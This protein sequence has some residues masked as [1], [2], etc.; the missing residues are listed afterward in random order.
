[1]VLHTND[2]SQASLV[3]KVGLPGFEIAP[4]AASADAKT[5]ERLRDLPVAAVGDVLG[6]RGIMDAGI[7]PLNR[8]MRIAGPALTV[9]TR[10]GDNLMIH[11]AL[12]IARP[13][14][15]LVIN[16]HGFSR[17][18]VWGM[19]MTHTA[20]A[21]GLAGL[22]VDGAIRDAEEIE[23]A[24]FPAYSRW[25]CP[26][27][28]HKDGP[29]TVN[30]PISCGGVPVRSGDVVLADGDGIVVIDPAMADHAATA[31]AA[32]VA[33]EEKRAREIL[34]DGLHHQSWLIPTLRAKGVLGPEDGL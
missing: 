28:P 16:G 18:A 23:A 25:V 9:E 10:P 31:G 20:M 5:I 11:A 26:A 29:G 33:A 27:G 1:M 2:G 34:E 32:K 30:L 17:S 21:V 12:K 22:I 6:R 15:V 24:G 4:A 3:D 19:L 7:R 8:R 13:G 14:D